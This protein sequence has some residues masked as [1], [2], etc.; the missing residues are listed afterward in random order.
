[1][2]ALLILAVLLLIVM[3]LM[4]LPSPFRARKGDGR[5]IRAITIRSRTARINS[6]R[7]AARSARIGSDREGAEEVAV[8]LGQVEALGRLPRAAAGEEDPGLGAPYQDLLNRF[9]QRT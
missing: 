4:R 3:A 5:R 1:M 6:A 8:L 7:M 9:S 2:R